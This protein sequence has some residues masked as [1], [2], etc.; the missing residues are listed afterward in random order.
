MD[1]K[2]VLILGCSVVFMDPKVESRAITTE[3]PETEQRAEPRLSGAPTPCV[4]GSIRPA[5]LV[6]RDEAARPNLWLD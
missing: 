6:R 2:L 1:L 5:G 4:N 3:E